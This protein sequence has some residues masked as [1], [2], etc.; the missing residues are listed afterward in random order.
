MLLLL[1]FSV[2]DARSIWQDTGRSHI[3]TAAVPFYAAADHN[4]GNIALTITN[5]GVVG[6]GFSNVPTDAFTGADLL[7]CEYPIDSRGKYLFAGAY[8]IGAVVGTDTLVSTGADGWSMPGNELHPDEGLAGNIVFRSDLNPATSDA[9]SNQDFVAVFYDTCLDCPGINYDMIDGRWHRPLNVEVTQKSY[10]WSYPYADDFV[11]FDVSV[12][13]IGPEP[14]HDLYMGLYMDG[15]VYDFADNYDAYSD[16]I[17]GFKEKM[18]SI[19]LPP[20][21][22][23]DTTTINLAWIADNDGELDAVSPLSPVSAVSGISIIRSPSD[24]LRVS[25]NWWVSNGNPVRDYGPQTYA[26]FRDL[27]T[28]GQGTPE[29]DRNKYHYLSNGEFDFDQVYTASISPSD[30]VW[31]PPPA[32]LAPEWSLG[33]DTRYLLSFG[34]FDIDPGETLPLTFAYVAGRYFHT[35]PNNLDNLPSDPA[36]YASHLSFSDIGMNALWAQWIYDNPGIDTDS[37]GFAGDILVC[38]LDTVFV[39]GDGV[40]DFRAASPPPAPDFWLDPLASAVK[41]RWN[42]FRSETARDV[43]S[44]EVDFEGYSVYMQSEAAPEFVKMGTYDRENFLK[45]T[46]NMHTSAWEL[47]DPPLTLSEWR[48]LYAPL[49]CSDSAWYPQDYTRQAPYRMDMYPDSIFYFDQY[50]C[51]VAQFGLETPFV[52]S[53]PE[54]SKP[55]Y[56][57][58]DDV[59]PEL[60]DLYLTP[61]GYFK[62]YEYEYRITDLLPGIGYQVVVTAFDY[63]NFNAGVPGLESAVAAA[64]QSVTPITG[65][66]YCCVGLVGNVDRDPLEQVDISDLNALIS[67]LFIDFDLDICRDE[68]NLDADEIGM[69]DVADLTKLIEYLFIEGAPMQNCP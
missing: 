3:R 11:L 1:A 58:P 23:A 64:A 5:H 9:V 61:D 12:R 43:F 8:W 35:D 50:L 25:Y 53:Y 57:S 52:K 56:D 2:S 44:G 17:T 37:D 63:G 30:P 60:E 62:Y 54:A 21:C 22:P 14:L 49:G 46:W 69:V 67:Y 20:T 18:P 13:N 10:A 16:D 31:V 65:R 32:S 42:G 4:V 7:S 47:R 27:S 19:Y 40:P 15:D 29:G 48:C 59:P 51:N 26:T 55:E 38:G 68:A 45:H 41:V 36:T 28:G 39:S 24:S 34:P 6:A 33:M 66:P